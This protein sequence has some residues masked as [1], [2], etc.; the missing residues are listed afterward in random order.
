MKKRA[1]ATIALPLAALTSTATAVRKPDYLD[2]R[3]LETATGQRGRAARDIMWDR[4]PASAQRAWDRF[5][6]GGG[7][8]RVQFDRTTE[9]PLRIW[10]EGIAVPGAMG[11]PDV[12]ERAARDLLG[13]HLALLAPGARATDFVVVS[14]VIH[15]KRGDMRTVGFH[16]TWNG[17]RVLG[18]QI[19][20]LFKKD[21]A[22]VIG[23]QAVPHVSATVPAPGRG[24]TA[25]VAR[26]RAAA[27]VDAAYA[28]RTTAGTVGEQVVLPI[29]RDRD[30]GQPAVEYRVVLPVEVDSAAPLARWDVYVDATT[31]EAVARTQKLR[32]ATG[33]IRYN[34]PQRHPG[35]TRMDY[36]AAFANF[37]IANMTAA[38]DGAG[39]V[40][41][42]GTSAATV[43]SALAGSFVAMSNG[44]GSLASTTFN[45][46]PNGSA[47]WN[48]SSA[49]LA[50]AQI[51]SFVHANIVKQYAKANLAP[52]MAYLDDQLSVTVN[53]NDT[54]NAY[55]T[56]DDIHFFRSSSQC[57]NTGRL[58]DVVYHEFGHSLHMQSIVQGAGDFDGALSEGVSDYLAAT[59]TNDHGMGRGF[60]HNNNALRDIDPVGSEKVWP[61]DVV[62]QVHDDGEIIGGTLWD[63]RK[64]LIAS[65]GADAGV[66]RADDLY[67]AIIQRASD[68]PSSYPEALAAD[69]DDGN[70]ANGTPNH[71]VIDNVFAIHGLAEGGG[72]VAIG[73]GLPVRDGF[74]V[75]VPIE[76]P[77]GGCAVAEVTG[78]TLQWRLRETPATSGEVALTST[79]SAWS[80]S[81]P[82]QA[83]GQVVQYQ[84]R[85]TL[86]DGSVVTYPDNP[87][88]PRYEFFVGPVT[89]IYCA[90]FENDAPDWMHGAT[91][92]T[93][94]WRTG[95]PNGAGG[96]ANAAFGGT[97][98]LGTDLGAGGGDG[99]Y[100]PDVNTWARSPEIDVSGHTNVRL[101]YRRWLRVEDAF[102][103]GATI[104][105]DGQQ[106]WSNQNSN[107]GND[108]ALQHLD[109]EWRFQDVDLTADAADGR[110]QITF[111]LASDGGL[112]FGGWTL[113]DVCIVA[114][115]ASNASCG[116][117]EVG[118]AEQ[119]DDGNTD[120]GDGC[121][122]ACQNE[123]PPEGCGDG[124]VGG[125]EECDDGNTSNGDGCSAVCTVE[126][127]GPNNP[128]DGDATGG[129]CSTSG[130]PDDA[131]GALALS[132]LV[133][134]VTLRR[135]RRADSRPQ[136]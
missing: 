71:C 29:V 18:G 77:S 73:V 44:A 109:K 54:C 35:G 48:Q 99:V 52:N 70:L 49:E 67:Y 101:Q 39:V 94:D 116:D 113:D 112:E 120:D 124:T 78:A 4:A 103:D 132:A 61:D 82:L 53:E 114:W 42:A 43:S 15:G 66:A 50:D 105:V 95:T 91:T 123:Q 3:P 23:S 126:D 88:D 51:I 37:R 81:I 136:L 74:R 69:D 76:E 80:G 130:S 106:R 131:M 127:G 8:W 1:L 12:A 117:G 27:W 129:C 10:G 25:D 115:S 118:G 86:E 135:R 125:A 34:A 45:L 98:V 28:T 75:S 47:V 13:E 19:S 36:P 64:G 87:A 110:V 111:G 65:L 32:F 57:A 33:T 17:M 128:G 90:D 59:I 55:S 2:E 46:M 21:R 104:S 20:F 72:A 6:A 102:F 62:G 40:T 122:A 83:E 30:D 85:V 97:R 58:A 9:V 100:E 60:F 107:M 134:L 31:G 5:L 56:G 93:D 96:D 11:S 119:C 68:I 26:A 16:Q 41:W 24:I 108:S 14:N 89:E 133:G 63:L 92:G 38:S 121:S 84:V 22:I 7:Q 79:P